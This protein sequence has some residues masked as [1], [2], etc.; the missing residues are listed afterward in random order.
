MPRRKLQERNIRNIQRSNGMY[1]ISIPI[2]IMKDLKWRER[3]KV[4]VV[5]YGKGKVIIKD[6]KKK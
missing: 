2:E 3:Q 5:R 4:V 6:W 1:Y